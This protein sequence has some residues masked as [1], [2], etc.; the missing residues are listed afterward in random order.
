ML[1]IDTRLSG[2]GRSHIIQE[3]FT[4]SGHFPLALFFFE[5]L[6][7]G[8]AAYLAKPDPYFTLSAG[9]VQAIF[10]GRTRN[11]GPFFRL[12]GN[13][14]A[15]AIYTTFEVLLEGWEFFE[16]PHHIA[17]WAIALTIGVMQALRFRAPH[18]LTAI[19]MLIENVV[20]TSIVLVMYWAF[21]ALTHPNAEAMIA[22]F[23][24]DN[25]HQFVAAV[26][27]LLGIFVGMAQIAAD[28]YLHLLHETAVQLR[29]YSEWFFGR[30][31][32]SHAVADPTALTL[33]R[34]QRA[35][36]FMDVRGF[37]QWSE[38]RTPE[39]VVGMLNQYFST[40]EAIWCTYSSIK[41][42]LTA[43]AR[44]A[45]NAARDLVLTTIPHLAKVGIAAGIG[46]HVGPL[47]EGLV[48]SER[49]Q[50]YDVIGDTVNTSKRLCDAARGGEILFSEAVCDA[51]GG[52]IPSRS[53]RQIS[54]KG[55]SSPL[56]VYSL[57]MEPTA[58]L[59]RDGINDDLSEAVSMMKIMPE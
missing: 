6:T 59:A 34:R 5:L 4:N 30:D 9:L 12:F 43:D 38:S 56:T 25:S 21:E 42:K 49:I 44:T 57:A 51:L 26:I 17:Y 11:R 15:P 13:L 48:G 53:Q 22:D 27:P 3:F 46:V 47:V 1:D 52:S 8:W 50:G 54:V 39:E 16:K 33:Q 41:V 7:D 23:L 18:Q 37:T 32:L 14:I 24:S 2:T 58:L 29:T 40:A 45:L 19:F 36:L 55:K 10:L 31:L 20:R 35:I 28:R